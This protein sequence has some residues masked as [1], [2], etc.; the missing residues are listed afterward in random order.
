MVLD[1]FHAKADALDPRPWMSCFTTDALLNYA[2]GPTLTGHEE[3]VAAMEQSM[4]GL[5]SMKHE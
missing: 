4:G 2:N 1:Q 5:R 3:I